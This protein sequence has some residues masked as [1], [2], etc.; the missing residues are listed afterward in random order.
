LKRR[1]ESDLVV[2]VTFL[3]QGAVVK[4]HNDEVES[5]S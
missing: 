3:Q 5:H 2:Q 1:G 4:L